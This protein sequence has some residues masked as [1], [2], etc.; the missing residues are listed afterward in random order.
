MDLAH[1]I[2]AVLFYRG[3]PVEKRELARL[4][5]VDEEGVTGAL[6]SLTAA[7]SGRGVRLLETPT[8]V[9]LVTAPELSETIETMR[10]E[11][12]KRD[13]GKAGAETLS[14]VLYRGPVSRTD[15]DYIRGVNSSFILRNLMMRGLVARAQNPKDSRTFVYDI[16]PELLTLLGV[17]SRAAL[18]DY[19]V[20]LAKLDQFEQE[21]T[22]DEQTTSAPPPQS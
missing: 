18:P 8:E 11:E 1:R 4:F 2:E 19:E 12:L 3:E 20:I 10:K 9:A 21:R 14:I 15:I 5:D 7:L 16:T 6:T 17:T 13:I 22:H